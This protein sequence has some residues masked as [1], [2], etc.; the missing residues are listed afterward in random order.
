MIH[1]N[2]RLNY[3]AVKLD[4]DLKFNLSEELHLFRNYN[5]LLDKYKITDDVYEPIP[6]NLKNPDSVGACPV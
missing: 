6:V 1:K 5:P 3:D 2:H 4:G